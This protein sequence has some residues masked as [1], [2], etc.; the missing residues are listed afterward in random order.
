MTIAADNRVRSGTR[1]Q[2]GLMPEKP[3]ISVHEYIDARLDAQD[4]FLSSELKL[5]KDREKLRNDLRDQ[6]VIMETRETRGWFLA[7]S[8]PAWH[9]A[10]TSW[11]SNNEAG[12]TIAVLIFIIGIA[13]IGFYRNKKEEGGEV[14]SR[15]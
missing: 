2:R 1:L 6:K 10:I 4:N 3:R 12:T 13:W 8:A 7:L 15:S 11:T 14:A 5:A 9:D